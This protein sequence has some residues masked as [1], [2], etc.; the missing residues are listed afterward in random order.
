VPK[1]VGNPGISALMAALVCAIAWPLWRLR[2][3][4]GV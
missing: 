2:A 1:L 3:G 4:R